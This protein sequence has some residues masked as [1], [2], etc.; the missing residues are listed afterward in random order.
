MRALCFNKRGWLSDY[1]STVAAEE[2]WR[3]VDDDFMS[4]RFTFA[5]C[6][7]AAVGV[8]LNTKKC[9]KLIDF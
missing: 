4:H 1:G 9:S 7:W 8:L 3:K 2:E 6:F 5:F